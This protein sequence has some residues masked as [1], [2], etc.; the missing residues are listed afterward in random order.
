MNKLNIIKGVL[1]F[2]EIV[3]AV[4]VSIGIVFLIVL[5]D[6]KYVDLEQPHWE[7]STQALKQ[8]M[9]QHLPQPEQPVRLAAE[10]VEMS[11]P[12]TLNLRIFLIAA[13]ILF[14][15]FITYILEVIKKIIKDVKDGVPFNLKNTKRVKQIGLL[16][17]VAVMAEWVFETIASLWL[18]SMYE[19]EGLK[20]ISKSSLGWPVLVL[21][22][23]II[24]LGIA[25][26]QGQKI[27]EENELT[28]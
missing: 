8:D 15:A 18:E 10:T 5:P 22:L 24:V 2:A 11:F 23:V 3:I 27:Q 12:L 1:V 26:E 28:V 13:L 16:V 20:L 25:L 6:G 19:F 4:A 17:T 14:S 9:Q 21:S 7:I